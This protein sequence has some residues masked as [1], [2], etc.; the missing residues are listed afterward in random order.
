MISTRGSG[1]LTPYARAVHAAPYI[2]PAL[3][4]SQSPFGICYTSGTTGIPKCVT[5]T[6]GSVQAQMVSLI[7]A[8]RLTS[9]DRGLVIAPLAY[10]G[11]LLLNLCP[12]D[13]SE[14]RQS[15]APRGS[16]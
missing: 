6:H 14:D 12:H 13:E 16:N 8:L 15:L 1:E 5:L 10:A 9:E 4:E 2:E 7:C 3:V 11:P